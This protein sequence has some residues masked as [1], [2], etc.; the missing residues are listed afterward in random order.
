MMTAQVGPDDLFGIPKNQYGGPYENHLLEQ[1]KLAV[2]MADNISARRGAANQ[3]FLTANSVLASLAG[4]AAAVGGSQTWT[5]SAVVVLSVVGIAFSFVWILMLW[6]YRELN[7]AKWEVINRLESRLP[8]APFTAEW[9]LI[10]GPERD[11]KFSPKY[12]G[13]AAI[14]S[15]IPVVFVVLHVVLLAVVFAA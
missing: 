14:E 6:T 5:M 13:L 9:N 8:A 10:K 2:G 12:R 3:F 7:R 11:A 4:V 15:W 1:Y